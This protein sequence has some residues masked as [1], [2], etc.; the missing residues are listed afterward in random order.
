M[1]ARSIK[2]E[3]CMQ[4]LMGKIGREGGIPPA[5]CFN[6]FKQ[7]VRAVWLYGCEIHACPDSAYAEFDE[8]QRRFVRFVL[9][10]RKKENCDTLMMEGGFIPIDLEVASRTIRWA[11]KALKERRNEA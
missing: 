7:T 5:D 6:I 2:A 11:G 4:G 8:K 3:R 1:K 9:R 10:L